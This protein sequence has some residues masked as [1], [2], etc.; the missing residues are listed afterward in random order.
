[1]AKDK[2]KKGSLVSKAE[3]FL[4]KFANDHGPGRPIE[5][6]NS[7]SHRRRHSDEYSRA[8]YGYP[9]SP[10]GYPS[11]GRSFHKPSSYGDNY[12]PRDASYHGSPSFEKDYRRPPS[13]ERPYRRPPSFERPYH[14]G[15]NHD[16]AHH[17]QPYYDG[18]Y[19]EESDFYRGPPS[20]N[21]PY[22]QGGSSH[23][24]S[25]GHGRPYPPD[26]GSHSQVPGSHTGGGH[27]TMQKVQG[28]LMEKMKDPVT[29]AKVE[30]LLKDKVRRRLMRLADEL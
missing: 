1:M 13:F 23:H 7:S 2:K 3:N 27:S 6:P 24:R 14:R 22:R 28:K 25:A 17:R 12:Y 30:R 26:S 19:G 21:G 29:Q 20:H 16:G 4:I 9:K 11:A 5:L 15:P 18:G 10:R 8:P